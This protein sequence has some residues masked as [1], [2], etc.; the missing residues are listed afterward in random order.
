MVDLVAA[1]AADWR[2]AAWSGTDNDSSTATTNTVTMSADQ[3]VTVTFELIPPIEYVLTTNVAAGQGTID[4]AGGGT[5]AAGTQVALVAAPAADWRVAAWSGTDNDSSTATTNTVTMSADQTVTVTF[6][7]IP[8]IQYALTASV[9]DGQG[10]IDPAGGSYA[11]GTAVAL[12][13]TPETGW[14]VAAW[15]GTDDDGSTAATNTVTMSA[16]KVVV[17]TFSRIVFTLTTSVQPD[18]SGTVVRSPDQTAYD[19]DEEVTLTA[20]ANPTFIF[21]W[22]AGGGQ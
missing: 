11:A 2:V 14:Q 22:L 3:T 7:L 19:P 5:Y 4:P 15:S 20:A 16:D 9:G 21:Q 12:T 13:A 18:G 8:L 6:E 10:T 17:V 1:P